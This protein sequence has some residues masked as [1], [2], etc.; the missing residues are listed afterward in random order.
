MRFAQPSP[1]GRRA[2]WRRARPA[3]DRLLLA[4]HGLV[5]RGRAV[6]AAAAAALRSVSVWIAALRA[7]SASARPPVSSLTM[8]RRW[9]AWSRSP[10]APAVRA[11]RGR[12]ARRHRRRPGRRPTRPARRLGAQAA[13]SLPLMVALI[14]VASASVRT[15]SADWRR[16]VSW[17][18][19]TASACS[20]SWSTRAWTLLDV[21]WW[22]R[23]LRLRGSR[24]RVRDPRW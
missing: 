20:L 16:R 11:R 23:G 19:A 17:R 5:R 15:A 10:R 24:W 21:C 22:C 2:R 13:T 12:S 1:A 4:A 14:V 3:V 6:G 9:R 7:V 8:R 18:C